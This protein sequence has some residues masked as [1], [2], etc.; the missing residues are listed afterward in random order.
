M[1]SKKAEV[2][3]QRKKNISHIRNIAKEKRCSE[4]K[5]NQLVPFK[6]QE[7]LVRSLKRKVKSLDKDLV[8]IEKEYQSYSS[9]QSIDTWIESL[10]LES[11]ND[12]LNIERNISNNKFSLQNFNHQINLK[13][14]YL[15]YLDI[16]DTVKRDLKVAEIDLTLIKIKEIS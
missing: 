13:K 8:A 5:E 11:L 6:D 3:N 7:K 15:E 16:L 2:F 14:L 1:K 4:L 9:N 10:S 12:S